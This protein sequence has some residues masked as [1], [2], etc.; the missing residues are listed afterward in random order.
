M[1]SLPL[2]SPTSARPEV[3]SGT[4]T[5]SVLP[6]QSSCPLSTGD[7]LSWLAVLG[8][9]QETQKGIASQAGVEKSHSANIHAWGLQPLS[10]IS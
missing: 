8:E 5:A 3:L 6:A 7:L 4:E 9:Q 2:L 1:C 10:T